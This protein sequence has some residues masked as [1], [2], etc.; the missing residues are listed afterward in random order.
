MPG[1][2]NPDNYSSLNNRF[3]TTLYPDEFHPAGW[4]AAWDAVKAQPDLAKS[5]PLAKAQIRQIFDTAMMFPYQY[6]S[7]RF[8]Y[9]NKA[10]GW[11]EYY[12]ANNA[13]DFYQPA[14]LWMKTK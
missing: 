6:D 4:I 7:S 11:A 12:Y 9:D 8:V 3:N 5:Y 2:P 1:F 10:N 13:P 14:E